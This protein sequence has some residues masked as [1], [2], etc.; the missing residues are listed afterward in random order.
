MLRY[1]SSCKRNKSDSSFYKSSGKNDWCIECRKDYN[2][3]RRY[4]EKRE[5]ELRQR[6][7]RHLMSKYKISLEDYEILL[8]EQDNS[9]FICKKIGKQSLAVDHNHNTGAVRGLLCNNCNTG[10][11]NLR[12]SID[13]LE[14]AIKYLKKY[15][16]ELI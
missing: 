11:G 14:R 7:H 15:K 6:R 16:T 10:L 3:K 2:D 12:E 5:L 13:N 1:C 8:A 4:G 9:C